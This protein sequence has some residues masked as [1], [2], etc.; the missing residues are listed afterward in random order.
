MI[1]IFLFIALLFGFF[2]IIDAFIKFYYNDNITFFSQ[3]LRM[4][5]ASRLFFLS[6]CFYLLFLDHSIFI[7]HEFAEV[8]RQN[9]LWQFFT[10]ELS[11]YGLKFMLAHFSGGIIVCFVSI[12]SFLALI[13]Y[14]IDLTTYPSKDVDEKSCPSLKE[15]IM[16]FSGGI[17]FII[18]IILLIFSYLLIAVPYH[19][20]VI[21]KNK[22]II[23]GKL[24]G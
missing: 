5:L 19:P 20:K 6:V 23:F 8:F 4:H 12:T 1:G 11:E 15:K 21:N 9:G 14:R 24:D 16:F 17:F 18:S 3:K 2:V 22:E 10:K 7:S 13:Y